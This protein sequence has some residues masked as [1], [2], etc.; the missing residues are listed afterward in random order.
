[1]KKN[2]F[3]LATVLLFCICLF[4]ACSRQHR[5]RIHDDNLDLTVLES[6]SI[7][8]L[9]ADYN[10]DK[11]GAVQR[12]INQSI[13]PGKLFS[14]AEDFFDGSAELKDHT[15]FHLTSSPGKLEI[16]LNKRENSYAA[17]TR[18]KSM[19]EGIAGILKEQ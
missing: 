19:C 4:S 12:Y 17:Y 9:N 13:E 8:K 15:R 14:S 1:M 3:P 6:N 18:I 16:K 7:Y 10:E 2:L 5:Y 11:T